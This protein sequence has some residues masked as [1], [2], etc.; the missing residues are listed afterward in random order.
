M[1][2]EKASETWQTYGTFLVLEKRNICQPFYLLFTLYLA[3]R[4]TTS[5][6]LATKSATELSVLNGSEE[7]QKQKHSVAKTVAKG[8]DNFTEVASLVVVFKCIQP[9]VLFNQGL[10]ALSLP[11]HFRLCITTTEIDR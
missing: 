4:N 1:V 8:R 9:Q 7:M 11:H 6:A 2:A 3:L 10:T 5:L